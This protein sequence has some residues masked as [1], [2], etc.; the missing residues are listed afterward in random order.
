M[1]AWAPAAL[2]P[3]QTNELDLDDVIDAA[4]QFAQENLDP[5]VLQALQSIDRDKVQD[6]LDHYQDYLRGDY[7]L[8]TA[9]LKDAANAILPL[10]E[11]HEET[12]PYAAWLRERWTILIWPMNCGGQ[13]AAPQPEPGK[14]L[15][16]RPNPPF[17][18]ERGDLDPESRAPS[19]AQG[20]GGCGPAS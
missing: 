7:V 9:Q 11:A 2:A 13:F 10:L 17:K 14:P 12:E 16:P 20:S 4:Q 6:F 15:P 18:A 3:A 1:F 8:D 19:V 5:S